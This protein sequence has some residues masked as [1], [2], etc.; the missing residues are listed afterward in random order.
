MCAQLVMALINFQ[1]QRPPE[2]GA[3]MC[4]YLCCCA[5]TERKEEGGCGLS[6][7]AI[8]PFKSHK[9]LGQS[10]PPPARH[11]MSAS[12]FVYVHVCINMILCVCVDMYVCVDVRRG[13]TKCTD[14]FLCIWGNEPVHPCVLI[15][16]NVCLCVCAPKG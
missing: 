1:S 12:D 15:F 4:V 11:L 3:C 2:D 8:K 14:G 7:K 13:V 5:V 16:F 10:K 9:V 6:R